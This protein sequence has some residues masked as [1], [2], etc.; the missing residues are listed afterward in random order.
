MVA[1]GE[2]STVADLTA[3]QPEPPEHDPFYYG[4]RKV[5]HELPDGSTRTEDTPLTLRD[6]LHPQEG[7]KFVEGSLHNDLRA[8]LEKVF[9]SRVDHDPGALVLSD[10]GIYWHEPEFDHHSP[11]VALIYGIREPR[12]NWPSFDVIEQGTR[13]RLIVE[14]VTPRYRKNDVV[15]KMRQYHQVHIPLYVILDRLRDDDPW[16]IRAYQWTPRH[17]QALPLEEDGRL[18]L[19]DLNLW[20]AVDGLR[21]RC[22]D[23]ST[24]RELE[25]YKEVLKR[26]EQEEARAEAEK[27]R[28]EAEKSRAEAEKS[29]ADAAAARNAE[30]EAELARLKGQPPTS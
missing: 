14:L 10:T 17:Y 9:W 12:E 21:I 4:R 29:R 20:L 7:D 1:G 13:P 23:G 6:H 26:M 28:A 11:D 18:W 2:M 24:D 30:L 27:S 5:W 19:A 25:D 3:K 22:F 15:D 16:V 8:Y